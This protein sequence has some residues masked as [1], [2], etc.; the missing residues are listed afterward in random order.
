MYNDIQLVSVKNCF[1]QNDWNSNSNAAITQDSWG[2]G[3]QQAAGHMAGTVVD[4]LFQARRALLYL[5]NMLLAVLYFTLT[6]PLAY[7]NLL[8]PWNFLS[9]FLLSKLRYVSRWYTDFLPV[10]HP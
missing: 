6:V 5:S 10:F 2:K 3:H 7:L 1:Y 8:R 4:Q 9:S